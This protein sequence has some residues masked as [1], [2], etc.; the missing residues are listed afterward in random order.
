[1]NTAKSQGAASG[2][3]PYTNGIMFGG[4]PALANAETWNGSSWTEVGDLNTGRRELAGGGTSSTNAIASGGD[5]PSVTGATETWNGT[6][7]TEVADLN[8]A[9]SEDPGAGG[10]NTAFLVFGG[11]PPD[12]ANTENW[13]GTAWT[14]LNDLNA[15]K[16]AAGGAGFPSSAITFG[17]NPASVNTEVWDG[18]SWT[19]TNNLSAARRMPGAGATTVSTLAISGLNPSNSEI[20]TTEEWT[21]D[22]TVATVTTS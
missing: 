1:M 3:A 8:T 6:S 10:S 18:T 7:W 11:G 12:K 20:A 13:N 16:S 9:R 5:T 17:A 19:E 14:E 22:L 15:A 21:A 2:Q 4:S